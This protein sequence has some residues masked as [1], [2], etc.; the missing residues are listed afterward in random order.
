MDEG[1]QFVKTK[2]QKTNF[3][4][5]PPWKKQVPSLQLNGKLT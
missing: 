1:G 4:K 3:Y 2:K 5:S